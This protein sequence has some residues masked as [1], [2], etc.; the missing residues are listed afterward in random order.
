MANGFGVKLNGEFRGIFL[1][2]NVR[3]IWCAHHPGTDG[4]DYLWA[5]MKP[6]LDAGDIST[7]ANAADTRHSFSINPV[8]R[9]GRKLHNELVSRRYRARRFRFVQHRVNR[10]SR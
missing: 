2:D 4:Y 9:N 1:L 6:R 10:V 7:F 3:Q 8:P 5:V